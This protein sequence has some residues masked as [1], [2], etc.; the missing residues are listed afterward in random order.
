MSNRISISVLIST[1]SNVFTA[2]LVTFWVFEPKISQIYAAK[3]SN[4]LLY[5]LN[6]KSWVLKQ[7]VFGSFLKIVFFSTLKNA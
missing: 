7:A 2:V 4:K 1:V 5:F 6:F 3:R